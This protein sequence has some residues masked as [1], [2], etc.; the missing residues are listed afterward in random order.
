MYAEKKGWN[1]IA[2]FAMTFYSH[3]I[4]L[5]KLSHVA[6]SCTLPAFRPTH[7]VI[8]HVQSAASHWETWLCTLGC[9]MPCWLLNNS[10]MN[11]RTLSR[12]FSVMIVSRRVL[13]LFIGC[14][15]NVLYAVPTT[16]VLS[17]ETSGKQEVSSFS[18]C[19]QTSS[20]SIWSP[21]VKY[22]MLPVCFRCEK[23]ASHL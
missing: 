2:Q 11:I 3:P 4:R 10:L 16:L 17:K 21:H 12:I 15:T 8:T 13:H 23:G 20:M 7:A 6:I 9:W 5:S 14:T 22:S 19:K 1:P 18:N